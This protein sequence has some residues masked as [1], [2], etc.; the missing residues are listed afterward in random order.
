MK[1][2][3]TLRSGTRVHLRNAV[4]AGD[5]G[6]PVAGGRGNFG[7]CGQSRPAEE[8]LQ[9]ALY[10]DN[11]ARGFRAK[12]QTKATAG[13]KN[14]SCDLAVLEVERKGAAPLAQSSSKSQPSSILETEL[15]GALVKV[16]V[17][18]RQGDRGACLQLFPLHHRRRFE[19]DRP[20]LEG[21]R[22]DLCG[23]VECRFSLYALFG[24]KGGS[25]CSQGSGC[26]RKAACSGRLR[27]RRRRS[28]FDPCFW[29]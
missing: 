9:R 2:N 22:V 23:K 6:I 11:L 8:V 13:K 28:G 10:Q 12:F 26:R 4:G 14:V 16:F 17:E 20:S 18:T 29:C 3:E 15:D 7:V 21:L 5:S 24:K 25:C 1:V 19:G 27:K